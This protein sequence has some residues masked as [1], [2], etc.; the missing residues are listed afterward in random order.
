MTT[1]R[2]SRYGRF[3]ILGLASL[4]PYLYAV[5]L[6]DLRQR[7]V[8]FLIAFFTAFATQ[9][10][11]RGIPVPHQF[12][13]M[14]PYVMTTCCEDGRPRAWSSGPGKYFYP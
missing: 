11:F 8:G 2:R 9:A 13:G 14:I 6:G 4:A 7:T 10:Q 1:V 5:S 12:V 3:L